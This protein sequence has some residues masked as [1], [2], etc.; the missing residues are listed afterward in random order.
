MQFHCTK[1][2]LTFVE[3]KMTNQLYTFLFLI[4]FF[5]IA[6]FLR[7]YLL[8]R[9]TGINPITF[10]DSDDAHAYNGK[11]FKIISCLEIIVVGIYSF[12]GNWYEYLLPFWYLD[13]AYFVI[14][15]WILL[16]SSLVWIFLAQLQMA[17]SWRI[18]I[19]TKHKTELVSKGFFS[20]SR[21]PIFLGIFIANLGLFLV[22]PNAFTLLISVLSCVV[23]QIQVRLEE[24]HLR[25][26]HGVR[27]LQYC[28]TVRRW[29]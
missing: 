1:S 4:V 29:I 20:I 28:K 8:W 27:Y 9:N 18:G 13:H 3:K 2:H 24:V 16:H 23:I 11:M 26:A 22:I 19:D 7:S 17:D 6:F 12:G 10:D 5:F 14:I 15:G 25:E 21:N